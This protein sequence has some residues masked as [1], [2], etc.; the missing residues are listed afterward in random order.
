M[1]KSSLEFEGKHNAGKLNLKV[2]ADDF[3][4]EP[5]TKISLPGR[6]C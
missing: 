4:L 3:Y 2:V 6:L 5:G 1:E